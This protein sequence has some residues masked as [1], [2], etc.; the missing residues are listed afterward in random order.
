M[1]R[2]AKWGNSPA[3]RIPRAV[4]EASGLKDGDAV[5]VTAL[6]EGG[7]A[8]VPDRRREQA[9]Q[10][11]RSLRIKIPADYKFDREEV[12]RRGGRG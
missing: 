6:P 12:S 11:L 3:V 10:K 4:M 7:V 9:I 5:V 8:I 2:V 1:S